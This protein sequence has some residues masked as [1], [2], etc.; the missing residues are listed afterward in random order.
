MKNEEW[1]KLYKGLVGNIPEIG[2]IMAKTVEINII[3]D[4]D[5]SEVLFNYI[6]DLSRE[7]RAEDILR[8]L[9]RL[10]DLLENIW[11]SEESFTP[12]TT[13]DLN[14]SINYIKSTIEAM[15]KR[16]AVNRGLYDEEINKLNDIW[17]KYK[18]YRS[19]I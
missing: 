6:N 16:K 3:D 4:T 8:R 18:E 14:E 7:D 11:D 2:Y 19:K 5:P 10:L 12:A 9:Y 17:E 13:L 15:K 1:K